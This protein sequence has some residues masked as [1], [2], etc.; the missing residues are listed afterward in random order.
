[1]QLRKGHLKMKKP[2]LLFIF[3][4]QHRK[5]DLGCY[6]NTEIATPNLDRL[7]ENGIRFE[8]CC[9]NSPVC[10][11][12]RGSILTGLMAQNHKAFTNDLSIRYDIQSIADV[13]NEAGYRTGYI[14]KWHLCGIPRNQFIDRKRR[15]GFQDWKVANCNHN[16]L[17]CYY[18]DENDVRHH[19]EGYEPEIFG[20]LAFEY[21]DQVTDRKQPFAIFVSFATPHDPHD[22]VGEEYL[23]MYEDSS[24]SMRA[25]VKEPIMRNRTTFISKERQRE[26]IRGY[27]A[28]V[29]AV[30]LQIGRM[31]EL[32]EKKGMLDHTLIVYT[33]DHGDM[34]GSQGTSDKQLPYEESIG[35]P[36]I[37]SWPERL[38][39]GVRKGLIGLV[40]LPVTLLSMMG[41][42]F[43]DPTDGKDLAQMTNDPEIGN[44]CCYLYDL[45]PCHQAYKKGMS[46]WR[47]IR[48]PR[49]TYAVYGTGE[50]WLLFDNEK[51]PLQMHNLI[52]NP[53][54][55]EV[56]EV[57]YAKLKACVDEY[58]GFM[59]GDEYIRY[60]GRIKEFNASQEYFNLPL[61]KGQEA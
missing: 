15:L 28:H 9:S 51:D 25:N 8:N 34:L 5:F 19:V 6:G 1:M 29:T 10:V 53:Q 46:A 56:K 58:D 12:A 14:G 43:R 7:A 11:P 20:Q 35:V 4:D 13:L 42:N 16:Y 41:L 32:L 30:D 39:P 52:Q 49:Y 22:K 44:E 47:G 21:L 38:N 45:Y 40:D 59:N 33:S 26:L 17:N 36:L 37:M 27:Y 54:Y 50:E 55:N 61:I 24:V 18:D 48:T 57:L 3:S 23:K 31:Q 60:S 2:N